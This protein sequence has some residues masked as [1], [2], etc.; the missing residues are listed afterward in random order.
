MFRE[1]GRGLAEFGMIGEYLEMGSIGNKK[2]MDW[3]SVRVSRFEIK[4]LVVGMRMERVGGRH[5]GNI[6]MSAQ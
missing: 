5:G 1:M 3:K 2:G 4:E 6:F